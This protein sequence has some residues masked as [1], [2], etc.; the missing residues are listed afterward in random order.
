MIALTANAMTGDR[1]AC[2]DA[3]ADD[4]LTKPVRRDALEASLA[5]RPTRGVPAA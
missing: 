1:E 5:V 4:Y 2:L 3:G